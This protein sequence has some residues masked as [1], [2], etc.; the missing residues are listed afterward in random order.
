MQW[1][2]GQARDLGGVRPR[3]EAAALW[4]RLGSDAE[5]HL[6]ARDGAQ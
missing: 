3:I 1:G 6:P 4:Q 5:T 2:A